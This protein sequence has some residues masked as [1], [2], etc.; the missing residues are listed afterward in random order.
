MSCKPVYA[1][2]MDSARRQWQL[3]Y[4]RRP[5]VRKMSY[6]IMRFCKPAFSVFASHN[7]INPFPCPFSRRIACFFCI[8]PVFFWR[9]H[10]CCSFSKLFFHVNKAFSSEFQLVTYPQAYFFHM[11]ETHFTSPLHLRAASCMRAN[12]LSTS[13]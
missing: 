6:P 9:K 11:R 8:Y 10:L 5:Y 3:L 7:S 12:K 13:R 1:T 4:I 2:V